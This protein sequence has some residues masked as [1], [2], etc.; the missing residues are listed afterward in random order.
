MVRLQKEES[1]RSKLDRIIKHTDDVYKVVLGGLYKYEECKFKGSVETFTRQLTLVFKSLQ[2]DPKYDRETTDMKVLAY[3]NAVCERYHGAL[4]WILLR[5]KNISA[6]GVIPAVSV[7][8]NHMFN[9]TAKVKVDLENIYSTKTKIVYKFDYTQEQEIE[10][11][12]KVFF[13]NFELTCPKATK[14]HCKVCVTNYVII[15]QLCQC[16]GNFKDRAEYIRDQLPHF[17]GDLR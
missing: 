14:G 10:K 12:T 16:L 9:F 3:Y 2:I 5:E 8:A 7:V 1:L 13:Q 11:S 6:E 15:R 4:T 17:D